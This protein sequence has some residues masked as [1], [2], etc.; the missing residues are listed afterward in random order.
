MKLCLNEQLLLK[1][2]VLP[3]LENKT[4]FCEY[5]LAHFIFGVAVT[6]RHLPCR[7]YKNWFCT[8]EC[9]RCNFIEIVICCHTIALI[10][11]VEMAI[12]P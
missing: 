3:N 6:L 8:R 11:M 1:V 12:S 10:K 5:D 4:N 2:L 9:K 7:L